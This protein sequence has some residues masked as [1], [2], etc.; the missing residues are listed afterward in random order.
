MH[1]KEVAK[2]KFKERAKA[3]VQRAVSAVPIMGIAAFSIFEKV[4]FDNWQKENPGGTIEE[5]SRKIGKEVK[6]LLANEY[7]EYSEG[8]QKRLSTL[9]QQAQN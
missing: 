5:Y 2:V 3:K 1:K 8:Y 7:S 9:E 6:E 4:E